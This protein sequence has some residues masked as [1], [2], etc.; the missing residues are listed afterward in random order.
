MRHI[1]APISA[2]LVASFMQFAC[3][4]EAQPPQGAPDIARDLS[5]DLA[6][7]MASSPDSRVE[8]PRCEDK[9][10]GVPAPNTGLSD[11]QCGP[12]CG[13]IGTE[14]VATIPTPELI[15]RLRTFE[16]S[17]PYELISADPYDQPAPSPSA[18]GTV[19]AAHIQG[20]QYTLAT[21]PSSESASAAGAVVTH[22]GACGLCSPLQDLTVYMENPDLTTPVRQCGLKSFSEG[23][24]AVRQCI[25]DLGFT[26]PCAQIWSYNTNHT[27]RQCLA[28][29]YRALND[30]YHKPDGSLNDCILCDEIKSGDVFKAVAGRTRRNTGLAS[31][32]CRPCQDVAVLK[33]VY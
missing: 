18:P 14:K 32:L 2:I 30:P 15:A 3:A 33:H 27:R 29:C 6:T 22:F 19:C 21:Y 10:F 1:K 12:S 26:E 28:P 11:E 4:Q 23:E 31:A 25:L 24:E 17:Q 7:D 8:A 5:Q 16:L 13:C 20:T 9:L